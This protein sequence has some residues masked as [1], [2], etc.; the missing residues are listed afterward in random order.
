MNF[1]GIT[2]PTAVTAAGTFASIYAAFSRFEQL[3]SATNR[4]FVA[5]WLK[6]I[7]A[8]RYDRR[9]DGFYDDFF[10]RFFGTRHFSVTCLGRSILL[11]ICILLI[12]LSYWW[13]HHRAIFL[14]TLN[15]VTN[16]SDE[17]WGLVGVFALACMVDYLS[18]F[19][20]RKILQNFSILSRY[21]RSPG[22]VFLD[23]ATTMLIF[24]VSFIV[25]ERIWLWLFH[26]D[27]SLS[28][29]FQAF[30]MITLTS[31]YQSLNAAPPETPF[32]VILLL[33]CAMM[34]SAWV[35][36]YILTAASVRILGLAP[37]L[38]TVLPKIIDIDRHPVRS[39]GFLIASTSAGAVGVLSLF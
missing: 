3:Q 16:Y 17:R 2:V 33:G 21:L 5:D 12:V 26:S 4:K 24:S 39:L 9:W 28:E 20:T 32:P 23:A 10:V 25:A 11:S 7:A 18:L 29:L 1:L 30:A 22:V 6:G 15:L 19:K 27:H 37:K 36:L 38:M 8:V 14:W 31:A 35:W 13:T 34:T